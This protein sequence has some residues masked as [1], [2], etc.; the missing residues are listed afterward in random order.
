NPATVIDLLNVPR[1]S[2]FFS[3]NGRGVYSPQGPPAPPMQQTVRAEAL[4]GQVF[5]PEATVVQITTPAGGSS[6]K[7]GQQVPVTV[8]ANPGCAINSVYLAA[9]G[10]IQNLTGT[11]AQFIATVP[12]DAPLGQ[13]SL[14]ALAVDSRG[15]F[16]IDEVGN[17]LTASTTVNITTDAPLM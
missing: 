15:N 7:V 5:S 12:L 10:P 17:L 8:T 13:T 3:P 4:S 11:P 1:N 16:A 6:V 9:F 14:M 2:E